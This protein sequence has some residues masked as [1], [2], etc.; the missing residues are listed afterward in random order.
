MPYL[1][2]E[3]RGNTRFTLQDRTTLGRLPENALALDDPACSS[4]HAVIRREGGAWVLEDLGSTN[5]TWVDGQ[6]IAGPCVLKEGD[7]IYMGAQVLRVEGLATQCQ[8]CGKEL[9]PGMAFCPG[10]GL[11]LKAQ[12]PPAV[13]AAAPPP[14]PAS[15]PPPVPMAATP[16][17]PARPAV[18]PPLPAPSMSPPL[19]SSAPGKREILGE[20]ATRLG[21]LG[22]PFETGTRADV[23]IQTVFLDASWGSGS[24]KLEYLGSALLKDAERTLYYYELTKESSSGFSFGSDSESSF[25]S[26]K[27]LFRKI[28]SV[29]YGPDGKAYELTLDLGAIPKAFQD[30]ARQ[31]GWTFKTVLKRDKA[32]Y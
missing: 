23:L 14:I 1:I 11:P 24:K 26:G 21:S 5:G 28:K 25:Q 3:T 27:T 15:V 8:R 7:R 22:I 6:R 4:R 17:L 18:P 29:R 32:S 12:A 13:P 20:I 9:R 19:P 31:Y 2:M 10:C 16:P 30:A